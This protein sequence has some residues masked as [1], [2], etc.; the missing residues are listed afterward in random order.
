M[1]MIDTR[2]V[3]LLVRELAARRG[4]NVES[5]NRI[6]A[7]V[8]TQLGIDVHDHIDDMTPTCRQHPNGYR[9]LAVLLTAWAQAAL[10]HVEPVLPSTRRFHL[11]RDHDVTGVSGSGH[12]A[13]GVLFP[14]GAVAIRWRGE[15]RS[16]V[17]WDAPDGIQHA[18]AIHGH[19]GA[20]WIVWDD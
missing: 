11:E 14:D 2:R 12:V 3:T 9:W 1:I 16:T 6:E 20:T 8:I 15:H 18:E 17:C 10:E 19:H 7:H 4:L 13:D 5:T